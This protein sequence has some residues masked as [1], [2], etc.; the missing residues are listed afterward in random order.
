M[1]ERLI[2]PLKWIWNTFDIIFM[3]IAISIAALP[4][5]VAIC[6]AIGKL[7]HSKGACNLWWG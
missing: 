6:W 1:K 3:P 4:I 7:T 2:R 5:G